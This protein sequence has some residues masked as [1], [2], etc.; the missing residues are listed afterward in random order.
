MVALRKAVLLGTL[1]VPVVCVAS[2]PTDTIA[3]MNCARAEAQRL[4]ARLAATSDQLADFPYGWGEGTLVASRQMVVIAKDKTGQVVAEMLC[5]YDKDGR[6][7][8]LH[9]TSNIE[10]ALDLDR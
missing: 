7:E 6:V 2:P 5:T 9:S 1:A 10:V 8:S 4:D 3:V